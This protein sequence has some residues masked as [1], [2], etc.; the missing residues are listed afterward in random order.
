MDSEP[1][2]VGAGWFRPGPISIFKGAMVNGQCLHAFH[3]EGA[4]RDGKALLD[5]GCQDVAMSRAFAALI[6]LQLDHEVW[7]EIAGFG[8]TA[9]CPSTIAHFTLPAHWGRDLSAKDRL[10]VADLPAGV[11]LIIGAGLLSF[12]KFCVD[13]PAKTWEWRVTR[14]PG[15]DRVRRESPH[16]NR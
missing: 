16:S 15:E 11:D 6:G 9:R 10:A 3:S 7:I 2:F 1:I 4:P 13:G 14:E 5:T 8:G 12:G